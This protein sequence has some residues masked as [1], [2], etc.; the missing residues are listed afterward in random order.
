MT[1]PIF[2]YHG[3]ANKNL[4]IIEPRVI[5]VRDSNEG[6]V[7]FAASTKARASLFI[8]PSDD[9]WTNKSYINGVFYHV[10]ADKNKY[11]ENDKGGAIYTL[12]PDNFVSDEKGKEWVSKVSVKPI[13]KEIFNSGVEAMEKHGVKIV[14]CNMD[15]FN[16]FRYLLK[17]DFIDEAVF[18]INSFH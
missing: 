11:L 14:F 15:F 6:P 1:K 12:D 2:L 10:I 4:T 18:L 8:V 13:D 5:T 16:K 7:V 3:S 17:N 9:S